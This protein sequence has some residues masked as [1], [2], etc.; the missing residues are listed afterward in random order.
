MILPGRAVWIKH[1]YPDIVLT[2]G[3]IADWQDHLPS[4]S[5]QSTKGEPV[6]ELLILWMYAAAASSASLI[7]IAHPIVTGP[8]TSQ[9]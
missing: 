3:K 7:A 9:W 6:A 2:Y 1:Q 4:Q 5:T 8:I